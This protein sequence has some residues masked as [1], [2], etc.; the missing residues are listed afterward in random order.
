VK[1]Q[2]KK[3]TPAYDAG[4]IANRN[5]ESI[6]TNPYPSSTEHEEWLSGWHAAEATDVPRGPG[7]FG[8][9]MG[10]FW[11][12]VWYLLVFVAV[13]SYPMALIKWFTVDHFAFWPGFKELLLALIPIVNVI[14][15]GDWWGNVFSF[16]MAII[17]IIS[18]LI[19]N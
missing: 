8:K 17:I 1:F 2:S 15:V 13:V 12:G 6:E 14:Y 3:S 16:F 7:W 5:L 10:K 18:R 11:L 9:A 4:W 19:T